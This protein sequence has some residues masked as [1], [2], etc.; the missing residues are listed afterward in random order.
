MHTQGLAGTRPASPQSSEK[1]W[2]RQPVLSVRTGFKISLAFG[3]SNR[4]RSDP[5]PTLC[6]LKEPSGLRGFA[7]MAPGS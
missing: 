5:V 3:V 6:P 1:C 7:G 2:A 4:L